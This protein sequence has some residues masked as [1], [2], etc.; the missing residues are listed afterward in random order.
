MKEASHPPIFCDQC[1]TLALAMLDGA[2]LCAKCLMAEVECKDAP[3]VNRIEPL[4]FDY[5]R[6]VFSPSRDADTLSHSTTTY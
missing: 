4:R 6:F 3:L 5:I 1:A 2:P